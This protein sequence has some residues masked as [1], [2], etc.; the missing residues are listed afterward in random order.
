M[1]SNRIFFGLSAVIAAS[2]LLSLCAPVTPPVENPPATDFGPRFTVFVAT[3]GS[4]A[5]FGTNKNAPV[6]SISNAIAKASSLGF[7]N[8]YIGAGVYTPGNGIKSAPYGVEISVNN[9]HLVGGWNTAYSAVSGYSTFDG[10]NQ[11]YTNFMYIHNANNITL[12]NLDFNSI[13]SISLY[14]GINLDKLSSVEVS[15]CVLSDI[16]SSSS[17]VFMIQYL[18]NASISYC[19]VF[20]IFSVDTVITITGCYNTSFSKNSI[21]NCNSSGFNYLLHMSAGSSN[22]IINS[23]IICGTNNSISAIAIASGVINH[24]LIGNVFVDN[25]LGYLYRYSTTPTNNIAA[26]NS[27]AFTKASVA[28]G[29]TI[30]NF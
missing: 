6:K 10:N 22:M 25:W 9:I 8:I 14:S 16:S 23:N 5:N 7:T 2:V 19:S 15:N 27:T 18:T 4:D 13:Q 30:T 17:R 28:S 21:S 29:N 20:N 26:V 12:K 24:K 3:N 11:T 1:K